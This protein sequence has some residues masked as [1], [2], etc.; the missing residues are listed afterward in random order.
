MNSE[1]MMPNLNV[2]TYTPPRS[3]GPADNVT[4]QAVQVQEQG[5][6]QMMNALAQQNQAQASRNSQNT[7]SFMSSLNGMMTNGDD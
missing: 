6:Q 7:G 5:M 4:Q 2:D 3:A 1:D